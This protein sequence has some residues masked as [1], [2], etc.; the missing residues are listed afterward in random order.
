MLKNLLTNLRDGLANGDFTLREVAEASGIPYTTL[1]E[2]RRE[3]YAAGFFDR[4][5]SLE[6]GLKKLAKKSERA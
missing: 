5:T 2:M 3:D 4:L 1:Q 6:T